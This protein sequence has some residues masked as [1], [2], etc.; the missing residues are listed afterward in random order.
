MTT[1]LAAAITAAV[2]F[3]GM[4]Y[5][6]LSGSSTLDAQTQGVVCA[7]PTPT[8]TPTPAGEVPTPE[9]P[10]PGGAIP[11][12]P[13]SFSGSATVAGNPIPDCTF[14]Y[15]TIGEAVSSLVPVVDGKYNG[16]TIGVIDQSDADL[17]VTFHLSEDTVAEETQPYF[18]TQAPPEPPSLSFKRGIVLTFPHLVTP[19]PTPVDTPKPSGPPSPTSVLPPP[20]AEPTMPPPTMTP[21]S[22]PTPL[23]ADNPRSTPAP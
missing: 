18:Y 9:P 17:P 4:L 6:T 21:T 19:S 16:L 11:A 15:A 14:V 20:T 22:T 10:A 3:G 13:M 1:R 7:T 8:P 12:F 2:L 5:F 23:T